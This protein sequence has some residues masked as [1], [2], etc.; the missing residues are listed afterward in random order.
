MRTFIANK[1]SKEQKLGLKEIVTSQE[2]VN[3]KEHRLSLPSKT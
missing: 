1:I 2:R 3:V